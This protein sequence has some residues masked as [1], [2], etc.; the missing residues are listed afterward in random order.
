VGS[1]VFGSWSSASKSTSGDWIGLFLSGSYS[2][3]WYRDM[4]AGLTS[5]TFST[6]DSTNYYAWVAPTAGLMYTFKYVRGSSVVG[7]SAAFTVV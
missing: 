5:G 2:A 4:D 3:L 7:T 6:V 1:P